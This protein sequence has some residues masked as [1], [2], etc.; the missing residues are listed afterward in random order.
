[1][2]KVVCFFLFLLTIS[3]AATGNAKTVKYVELGLNQSQFR[4]QECKSKIGPSFGLGL[5]YYP[6]ESIHAFIG[7]ELLYQNKKLLLEDKTWPSDLHPY[8]AGWV[9]TGDP[10]IGIS[11]LEIPLQLGYSVKLD[12]RSSLVIVSGYS[13]AIAIK[14]HTKNRN[15]KMR[16]LTPDERGHFNFDYILLD[17]SFVSSSKNTFLGLRLS[18]N[19]F[20][21]LIYYA[22]ALSITKDIFWKNIEGKIDTIRMSF[23]FML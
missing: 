1:M 23:A 6:F 4:N 3:L 2:K 7:T 18:C 17:E 8:E 11:Y 9:I 22:K 14:D 13:L 21:L 15:R 19:R 10:N 16:E 20:F 5:D 12:E